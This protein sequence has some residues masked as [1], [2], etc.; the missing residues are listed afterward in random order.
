VLT[1]PQRLNLPAG[2]K[3]RGLARPVKPVQDETLHSDLS[4]LCDANRVPLPDLLTYLVPTWTG[5]MAF[6]RI[7]ALSAE[8]LA[9]V[10]RQP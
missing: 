8:A 10:S 3:R 2:A 5:A 6:A 9:A 1:Q 4:R 7:P